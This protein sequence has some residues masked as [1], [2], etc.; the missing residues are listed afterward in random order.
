MN[1]TLP[2]SRALDAICLGRAGVDLYAREHDTEFQDVIGF[3]KHV[4]GSPANIAIG[5]AILG[6]KIAVLSVVSNDMLG[7]YVINNLQSFGI[8][9]SAIRTDNSGSRT[10]LAITEVKPDNCQVVI[11]RNNASDLT[12]CEGDIPKALI[13]DSKMLVVSGTALSQESSRLATLLALKTSQEHS[14]CS[15]LDIDYRP[16]SW[17]HEKEAS[18]CYK[19]AAASCDIIVGNREEFSVLFAENIERETNIADKC[20]ALGV[21]QL[22][23]IKDGEHGSVL[24]NKDG[25]QHQQAIFPVSALKPFGAGDAFAAA[26]C[27]SLINGLTVAASAEKGAAAAAMVVARNSCGDATPTQQELELFIQQSKPQ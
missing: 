4:G 14:T 2:D 8:N 11:Y 22:V 24:I 5:M 3:D 9:T 27:V 19:K 10:S 17:E 15:L 23:I 16:Y 21:K 18:T 12:L 6:S 25:E 1:I 20:F 26:F 13:A 7:N